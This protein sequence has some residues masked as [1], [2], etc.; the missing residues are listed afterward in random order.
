MVF[1]YQQFSDGRS[2]FPFSSPGIQKIYG[3]TPEQVQ[4][5][6]SAVFALLHPDDY[7]T[8]VTSIEKSRDSLSLWAITYRT[9]WPDGSVYWLEGRSIPEI[10]PDG[11]VMWNGY[12][13]DVTTKI[14]QEKQSKD[15]Q[16]LL[17]K[18]FE[19]SPIGIALNDLNSGQ[20]LK[21]NTAL[22]EPTGYSE[23][24]FLGLS[25]WQ[26]TPTIY[27]DDE[28]QQ[29][30]N[31]RAKGCYGP[32]EKEYIR[33]N[34]QRY[35]VMLRGVKVTDSAGRDLIWS[36]I[37]DMSE[38]KNYELKLRTALAEAE[39]ATKAKSMFL[40]NM[41]HEIRTPMNGLL[42]MLEVLE[43]SNL[44]P[45]QHNQ[46]AIAQRSG[47][48]LLTIIND[49]LDFSKI[50]AGKL[51]LDLIDFNLEIAIKDIM[52]LHRLS[53]AQKSIQLI[54]DLTGIR[55]VYIHSDPV[56]IKQVI[57]NLLSNAI[58]FTT[59]GSVTLKVTTQQQFD[60]ILLTCV[61]S[62]TGIGMNSEQ[63][64]GLFREFTQA[65]ASTTRRFG[66]TGLGLAISK[67]LALMLGGDIL[68][69]S[70]INAGSQFYF[71]SLV[72]S[73]NECVT[74]MHTET[75]NVDLSLHRILIVE[76]N[77][78]NQQVIL[79]MLAPT[80]ARLDVAGNGVDAIEQLTASMNTHFSIVLMDCLMPQMDGYEATKLIRSGEAGDYYKNIPILALTANASNQDRD[81]CLN[82]GMNDFLSK[83][84]QIQAL[85]T[86]IIQLIDPKLK[87]SLPLSSHQ[88]E[89]ITT[90]LWDCSALRS[91]LG[92]MHSIINGLLEIFLNQTTNF[93][94]DLELAF[95][96]EPLK[97]QLMFHTLKGGAAQ[98][99][100]NALA[101]MCG[102]LE[103]LAQQQ[104]FDEIKL[105]IPKLLKCLN[106]TRQQMLEF[107]NDGVAPNTCG[108]KLLQ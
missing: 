12:I 64:Q 47:H 40:A 6:A 90:D 94:D 33:K 29:L 85:V 106:A 49:I 14:I 81:N 61:V 44:D 89:T 20:F 7:P 88:S 56:R 68:V 37:E 1:Q 77:L 21:T 62:D 104:K 32:Y 60:S 36:I 8:V 45:T 35:P 98:L 100:C 25:Y 39:Q 82:A 26:L 22:I 34:G 58:K 65:D 5:D 73:A 87:Q 28:L 38:R 97:V 84:I 80:K 4:H 72:E 52:E 30:E 95:V 31:L 19:L 102:K 78:V 76:D 9:L 43:Q 107:K 18:L 92:S 13:Q 11:S 105:E 93:A 66:G 86:K 67:Q 54:E 3:V 42:G 79:A 46:I 24:E 17:E 70:Q 57:N 83:P 23:T 101:A 96:E 71:N 75:T 91:Q 27:Q 103:L 59:K 15:Y 53:A 50:D 55:D 2:C 108:Q 63:K 48:S 99:Q 69:E 16:L 74:P 10:L 41:S 51:L